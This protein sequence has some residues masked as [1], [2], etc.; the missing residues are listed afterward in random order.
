MTMALAN[1]FWGAFPRA[2][3][4]LPTMVLTHGVLNAV[5]V[6]P[7]FYFALLADRTSD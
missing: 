2:L 3:A 5:V 7:A 4:G 6:V 1:E